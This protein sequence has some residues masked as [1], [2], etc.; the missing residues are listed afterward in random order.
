MTIVDCKVKVVKV[1][2]LSIEEYQRCSQ[3]TMGDYG[4][5]QRTLVNC[6]EGYCNGTA[7][8]LMVNNKIVSWA[9]MFN[10]GYQ[11]SAHFYTDPNFR[12]KGFGKRVAE[13]VYEIDPFIQVLPWNEVS[14]IFFSKT[15]F[16]NVERV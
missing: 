10:S 12:Q 16:T 2:D 9:L 15:K 13:S 7:V 8:Y 5:M 14:D 3:L 6:R 1:T 4:L 11:W